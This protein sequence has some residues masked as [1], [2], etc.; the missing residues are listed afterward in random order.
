MTFRCPFACF[1]KLQ[2]NERLTQSSKT[3]TAFVAL[4]RAEYIAKLVPPLECEGISDRLTGQAY[5][6]LRFGQDSTTR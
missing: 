2:Q 1:A 4:D 3:L 5:P 6:R